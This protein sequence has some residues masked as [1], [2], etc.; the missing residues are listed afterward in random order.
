MNKRILILYT[1]V[2]FG[3]LSCLTTSEGDPPEEDSYEISEVVYEETFEEIEV[4]VERLNRIISNR[5]YA[6]WFSYLTDDYK[7]Y[8]SDPEVLKEI[9]DTSTVLTAK[10]IKLRTLKDYFEHVVVPS[11]S[12][13]RVSDIAFVAE[14]LL[15]VY[16]NIGRVRTIAY[17]LERVDNRWLI[18]YWL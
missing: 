8:F 9:T 5:R 1:I 15:V 18:G 2:A 6:E 12:N 10:G 3:A 16:M 14:D 4:F 7:G 17:Q 11:R 13:A